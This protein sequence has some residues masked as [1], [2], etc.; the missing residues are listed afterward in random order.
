MTAVRP[1]VFRGLPGLKQARLAPKRKLPGD[2]SLA[3]TWNRIGGL[4]ALLC[5]QSGI[6]PAAA[7]AV[8]KVECGDLGFV[9]GK[10]VLRFE[11]HILFSRWG[12]DHGTLFD[13]H[14][15]FGGRAGVEGARWQRHC[16]RPSGSGEWRT[17]HGDQ[18]SEYRALALAETLAG[19]ETASLCAS[20]GGPQ[21]MGFNHDVIGYESAL[22]MRRAFERSERWQ[23]SGFFDFCAVKGIIKALQTED[24]LSFA[25]TYNGP[26]NAAAYAAKIGESH[27]EAD[28]LLART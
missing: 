4:L 9:R 2:S 27:I 19:K 15:Q 24:W 1:G 21:I 28:H 12:K 11:P 20:F 5:D 16:Y 3:I 10:P 26:G 25:T 6:S 13:R 18:D 14:F 17:F 8:W 22:S 23:V 7:L